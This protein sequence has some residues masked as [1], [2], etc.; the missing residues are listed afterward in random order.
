MLDI[1]KENGEKKGRRK[2]HK[3][4]TKLLNTGCDMESQRNRRM[5]DDEDP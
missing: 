2:R 4:I 1:L 5:E 3:G